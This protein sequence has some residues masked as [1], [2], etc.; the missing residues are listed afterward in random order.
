MRVTF[1]G[2]EILLL[3]E[4]AFFWP[5]E[6]LLGF[7]DLHLGKAHS[8]QRMGIPVPVE[9]HRSDLQRIGTLIENLHPKDV[10]IL[11]DFIHQRDSWSDSLIE[12]LQLF[13][14][15]YHHVR[16]TLILGNHE[17]G[18]RAFLSEL[19]ITI[20]DEKLIRGPLTF[21]H[22]HEVN[23]SEFQI[24]G[25]VHPAVRLRSGSIKLRLPC[26]SIE[27]NRLLLPS[28]GEL[29]GGFEIEP[30]KDRKLYAVTPNEVFEVKG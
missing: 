23:S 25:H 11:G 30:N 20:V 26:F 8:L 4:K 1:A 7:S 12:L 18:S 16:W 27:K 13:F 14:E 17:R 5:A 6:E 19:P 29:T 28:F 15:D 24:E 10:V 9:A 3:P 21:S 2:E 22:G